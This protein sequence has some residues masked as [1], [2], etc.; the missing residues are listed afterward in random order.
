[1]MVVALKSDGGRT[2]REKVQETLMVVHMYGIA[3]QM[4]LIRANQPDGK[5]PHHV[6]GLQEQ[7]QRFLTLHRR[8]IDRYPPLAEIHKK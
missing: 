3:A 5:T 7:Q 1:M 6:L 2:K 4:A 8:T